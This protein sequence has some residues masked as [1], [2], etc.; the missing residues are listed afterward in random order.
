[1][2]ERPMTLRLATTLAILNL[3]L[4]DS[5]RRSGGSYR[6]DDTGTAKAGHW[7]KKRAKAK[8]RNKI[9]KA[10]RKRNR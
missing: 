3:G 10:S 8:R 2:D 9:A 1:M 6:Y 4:L 7:Q 5:P